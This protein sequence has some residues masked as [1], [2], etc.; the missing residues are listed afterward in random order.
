METARLAEIDDENQHL[1]N[2]R[3]SRGDEDVSGEC[4][5]ERK[6]RFSAA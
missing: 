4:V 3:T 2:P 1:C 5:L 6:I